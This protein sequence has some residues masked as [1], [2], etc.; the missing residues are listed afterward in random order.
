M[1][2][3]SVVL[4]D[5]LQEAEVDVMSNDDC[6]DIYGGGIDDS[7]ICVGVTGSIG[8]CFVSRLH[9]CIQ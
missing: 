9:N 2:S 1:E 5:I 3:G 4:P 8:A 7:Q 6:N